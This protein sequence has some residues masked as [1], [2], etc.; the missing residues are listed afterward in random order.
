MLNVKRFLF[1]YI[2]AITEHDLN[3]LN[4]FLTWMERMIK[5]LSDNV[6]IDDFAKFERLIQSVAVSNF[7]RTI[8]NCK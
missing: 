4:H 1:N 6:R 3:G 2:S 5:P 8:L 7:I